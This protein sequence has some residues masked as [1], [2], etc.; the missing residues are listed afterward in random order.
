[1]DDRI[2][3]F[4]W[5]IFFLDNNFLFWILKFPFLESKISKKGNFDSLCKLFLEVEFQKFPFL[6][7]I[8]SKTGYF[9]SLHK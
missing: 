8:L 3:F 2:S 9:D 6:N 5:Q 7:N 1:L 4:G